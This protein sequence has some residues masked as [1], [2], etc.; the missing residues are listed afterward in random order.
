MDG[1]QFIKTLREH[2]LFTTLPII[3]ITGLTQVQVDNKG[4][5]PR[6]VQLLQKPIDME[7]LRGFFEALI[8]VKK[9]NVKP[10]S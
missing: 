8:A 4:G 9:I 6:D 5:L 1:F 10:R 3:A 2:K 7:W